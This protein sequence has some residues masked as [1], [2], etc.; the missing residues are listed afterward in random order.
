MKR[1]LSILLM[2]SLFATF[3]VLPVNADGDISILLNGKPLDCGQ[4]PIMQ[5]DRVLLP[6]RVI[7]EALGA[8]VYWLED[9]ETGDQSIFAVKNEIKL[10][11]YV[12]QP[13]INKLTCKDYD[14]YFM[15]QYNLD[16]AVEEIYLDVNIQVIND[17]AMVPVRAISEALGI[18]VDWDSNKNTVF[19]TGDESYIA[20]KNTDK[21]FFENYTTSMSKAISPGQYS[22]KPIVNNQFPDEVQK[23]SNEIY[24]LVDAVQV[25]NIIAGEFG[26]PTGDKGGPGLS[27]P[28]WELTNGTLTLMV[29]IGVLYENESGRWNLMKRKT[30]LGDV[31]KMESAV[32]SLYVNQRSRGIGSLL[33]KNDNTYLFAYDTSAEDTEYID[34]QKMPFFVAHNRGTWEIKFEKE[35]NYDTDINTVKDA[36]TIANLIFTGK[37]G[38]SVSVSVEMGIGGIVFRSDSLN[39]TVSRQ[40]IDAPFTVNVLSFL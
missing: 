24:N 3:F 32:Y 20:E 6:M 23:L 33:L 14:D 21:T 9:A 18:Q 1:I 19:L 7:F 4:P 38:E 8:D 25:Y 28:Y 30:R 35:Y 16:D 34:P 13:V 5:G 10:S 2:V 29:T 26:K 40:P 11:M 36:E 17:K 22:D 15:K 37:D 39:C 31:M 27:I 12:G